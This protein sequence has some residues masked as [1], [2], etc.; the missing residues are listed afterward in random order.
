[1]AS[2]FDAKRL[3]EGRKK[4]EGSMAGEQDLFLPNKGNHVLELEHVPT[5]YMVRFPAYLENFSDAYTQSWNAEDVYGRMDPIAVFQNTRRAVAMSWKVPASSFEQAKE[6][7]DI[8]NVLM[9]FMYPL[10]Q[11]SGKA[12]QQHQGT[13]ISMGPLMKVKFANLV[14]AASPSGQSGKGLMGYINGFTVDINSDNGIFMENGGDAPG[15]RSAAYYPK[16]V[17]LNFELNVLHEHPL[18]WMKEGKEYV[19]RG[20]NGKS[21]N[22]FP[23]ATKN[24]I[25]LTTAAPPAL[26]PATQA[27]A[28]AAVLGPAAGPA[29]EAQQTQ[30]DAYAAWGADPNPPVVVE[31]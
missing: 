28:R 7:L 27:E 3:K 19:W 1:M 5:G 6:N 22:G 16:E 9:S 17:T 18:G 15:A 8:I 26:T 23:Y 31:D 29:T 2:V 12:G 13:T 21:Y 14:Q 25:P 20:A 30:I 11:K 24:S 4:L 10:Y